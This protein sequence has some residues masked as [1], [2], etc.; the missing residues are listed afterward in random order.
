MVTVERSLGATRLFAIAYST[1]GSS[2]YFAL[3]VVAAFAL[4]LT[5]IVF[6]VAGIL[7]V[8]TT[9]TYFEGMTLHP[10]RGGSAV[11]A[12]FAFNELLSFVAINAS[13]TE[14]AN[15]LVG[16]GGANVLDG[17]GGN[18]TLD[19]SLG[20]EDTLIGGTGD[21]TFI[22]A[23][24]TTS[25]DFILK[26]SAVYGVVAEEN[27]SPRLIVDASSGAVVQRLDY[28][29]WGQV[30]ADSQPGFQPFGFAGAREVHRDRIRDGSGKLREALAL[31]S[32][33]Q[34]IR[35]SHALLS[36]VAHPPADPHE[37]PG[38]GER[39]GAQQHAIHD[40]EDR[41]VRANPECQRQRTDQSEA[42][43]L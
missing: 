22:Y 30:T 32:I 42:W 13:G 37:P 10:E 5:P 41:C 17:R 23:T 25:P 31:F 2:I 1:V 29:D 27:G 18:D 19:G 16:N 11:M 40:A 8:I 14:G 24:R 28:D 7:F 3:G 12:R 35:R 21:D 15:A 36:V 26:G 9:L 4:G 34:E 39:Q 43:L 6:L 38:F 33:V 20:G